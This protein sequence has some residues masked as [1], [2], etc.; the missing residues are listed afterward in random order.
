[1]GVGGTNDNPINS[2]ALYSEA[3]RSLISAKN[4]VLYSKSDINNADL[5]TFALFWCIISMDFAEDNSK[6]DI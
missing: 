5:L 6:V 3:T 1:M 2:H 4:A